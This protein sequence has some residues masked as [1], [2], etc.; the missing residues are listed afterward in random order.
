MNDN[1][2]F[3]AVLWDIDGT[4]LLSESMHF[5]AL[6]HAVGTEGKHVPDEFHH[7][8]IGRAASVV[9]QTARERF[10]LSMSFDHFRRLK[11]GYY[12]EH[13]HE[14]EVRP[15]ALEAWRIFAEHGLRQ[16]VVSNSDR[17][18][19]NA[20]IRVLGLE[21]PGFISVSI[22]DVLNGKPHPEPY[23]RGAALL[24]VEPHQC[25]AVEDSPTG[26]RAALAAGTRIIAWPEDL[27]LEF[28]AEIPPIHDL[29][30]E[31]AKVLKP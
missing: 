10:G 28:P 27:E 9:Y 18:V 16:A 14:I 3:R 30:S 22:N 19:V 11:Y 6:R 4:L 13:A 20:N 25:I 2:Q 23:H 5:R 1:Q 15:G 12:T 7:E 21:E 26:A 24:G 17:I 31:I 29:G 8:I